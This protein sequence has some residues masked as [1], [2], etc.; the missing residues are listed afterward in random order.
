MRLHTFN[1]TDTKGKT[2]KRIV[3][4]SVVPTEML[5]GTD[6]SEL[7]MEEQAMY[8]NDRAAI[9]DEYV[10][11]ILELDEK[12]DLKHRYRQFKKDKIADMQVE[13]L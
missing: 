10:E 13:Y 7:S 3:Y 6:L 12:Y 8:A 2:T 11:K 4:A 1:Y 5:S 9:H